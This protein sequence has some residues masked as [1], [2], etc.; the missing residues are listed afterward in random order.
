[1]FSTTEINLSKLLHDAAKRLHSFAANRLH[2][3]CSETTGHQPFPGVWTARRTQSC[4][5]GACVYP[6][7]G[8][9]LYLVTG[10]EA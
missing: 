8:V 3:I 2:L 1:M 6:R 10:R 9:I 5:R 4:L 7:A